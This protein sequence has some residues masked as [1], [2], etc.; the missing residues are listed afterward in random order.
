[1][2][3]VYNSVSLQA[4]ADCPDMIA[5][6]DYAIDGSIRE[7][8]DNL[9]TDYIGLR[10]CIELCVLSTDFHCKVDTTFPSDILFC[11]SQYH[12]HSQLVVVCCEMQI[13]L[14]HRHNLKNT[15]KHK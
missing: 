13:V 11:F 12:F 15:T 7:Q 8:F 4:F 5:F 14:Q 1:M 3:F 9:P 6:L 2:L 10:G